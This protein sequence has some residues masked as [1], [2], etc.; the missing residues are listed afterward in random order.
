MKNAG[1]TTGTS[2]DVRV[3]SKFVGFDH[4]PLS[5]YVNRIHSTEQTTAKT[6]VRLACKYRYYTRVL[7][8]L[9]PN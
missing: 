8:V 3:G 7:T 9:T 6:Y 1:L 2:T 4:T 5:A